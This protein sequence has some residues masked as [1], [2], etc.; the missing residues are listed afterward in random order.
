MAVSYLAR[1]AHAPCTDVRAGDDGDAELA[2]SLRSGG[3]PG[4]TL[5]HPH[6]TL[7]TFG[8]CGR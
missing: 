4:A 7:R 5:P 3:F 1:Y 2:D 6:F 8:P